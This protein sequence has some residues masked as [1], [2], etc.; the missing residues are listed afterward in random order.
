M[1]LIIEN[2]SGEF[3]ENK[4]LSC[5]LNLQ[6]QLLFLNSSKNRKWVSVHKST[7]WLFTNIFLERHVI[8]LISLHYSTSA[9]SYCAFL[10]TYR[11]NFQFFFST[12]LFFTSNHMFL[13]FSR[14]VPQSYQICIYTYIILSF[15]A[16][17][18]FQSN[19]LIRK[20]Q[21]YKNTSLI[22]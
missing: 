15:Q 11:S 3:I 4:Q 16:P 8:S 19:F 17:S 14:H 2:S 18:Q 5:L 22:E 13:C 9:D 7:E 20:I 1:S 10:C 6:V 12:K 21:N